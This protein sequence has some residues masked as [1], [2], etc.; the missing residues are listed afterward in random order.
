M[1][2]VLR[3]FFKDDKIMFFHGSDSL[4]LLAGDT[5]LKY[6]K[7]YGNDKILISFGCSE[8]EVPIKV[9]WNSDQ[10]RNLIRAI[11]R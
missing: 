5:Y 11:L 7:R 9:C 3:E 6:D 1:N 4:Q 10:L 8:R 2:D